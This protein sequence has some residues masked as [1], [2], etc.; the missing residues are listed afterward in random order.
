MVYIFARLNIKP[1]RYRTSEVDG[2][3]AFRVWIYTRRY[4]SASIRSNITSAEVC[5]VI[6]MKDC[7]I[8]LS[9]KVAE[10]DKRKMYQSLRSQRE[11]ESGKGKPDHDVLVDIEE[12]GAD[13][14]PAL[15]HNDRTSEEDGWVT[16]TEPIL[17]L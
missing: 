14:M 13:S 12:V 4:V 5:K 17:F 1:L 2:R 3:Q 15:Q 8:Q 16:V 11:S 6:A 9:V 7:P 10:H